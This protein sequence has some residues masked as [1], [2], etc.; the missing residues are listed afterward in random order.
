M[1]SGEILKLLRQFKKISQSELAK[2][3]NRSQETISYWEQQTH[4]NGEVLDLLLKGLNSS[5][6]E[7][8]RF[9]RLPPP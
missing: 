1:H 7:W 8:E 5:K 3:I 9:K 4:L 6:E 2:R